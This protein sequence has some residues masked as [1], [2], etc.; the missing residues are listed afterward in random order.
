MQ[1]SMRSCEA[2]ILLR[3]E[4]APSEL[5]PPEPPPAPSHSV[6]SLSYPF[7]SASS[8]S[9]VQRPVPTS[10]LRRFRIQRP[11][12]CNG[13]LVC[14]STFAPETKPN[15]LGDLS[16]VKQEKGETNGYGAW[17]CSSKLRQLLELKP[18]DEDVKSEITHTVGAI[19]IESNGVTRGEFGVDKKCKVQLPIEDW[20]DS[21]VLKTEVKVSCKSVVPYSP[22]VPSVDR[23]CKVQLPVRNWR[24]CSELK[25][26][27]KGQF[28]SMVAGR[29]EATEYRGACKVQLPV[30]EWSS[31]RGPGQQGQRQQEADECAALAAMFTRRAVLACRASL[32]PGL[33]TILAGACAWCA[34]HF[35][36]RRCLWYGP[37]PDAGAPRVYR[38]VRGRR[39]LCACCPDSCGA[40][41]TDDAGWYGKGYRKGRRRRKP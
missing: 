39:Y 27:I 40:P 41:L 35:A 38:V 20:R 8:T 3:A 4:H 29:L 14:G 34:R 31:E 1:V 5:P 13:Q 37:P 36:A 22:Q 30:A 7:A 16:T 11:L 25:S 6:P 33:H 23:R 18:K 32:Y 12:A 19:K 10:D 9:F 26:E 21:S 2:T 15:I 28:R 17:L 24:D